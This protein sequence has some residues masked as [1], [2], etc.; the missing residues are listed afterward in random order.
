MS[1]E[2]WNNSQEGVEERGKG[3]C[4]LVG[5]KKK[6]GGNYVLLGYGFLSPFFSSFS[7][8]LTLDFASSRSSHLQFILYMI[9][10]ITRRK[11]ENHEWKNK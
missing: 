11:R 5:E 4:F 6:K 1:F 7:F 2:G 9:C 3:D 10:Q 8:V